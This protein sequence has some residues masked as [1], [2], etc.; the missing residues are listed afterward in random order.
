MNSRCG[1]FIE[2]IGFDSK[3]QFDTADRD[4]CNDLVEFLS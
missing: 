1:G 4:F 3:G 2:D